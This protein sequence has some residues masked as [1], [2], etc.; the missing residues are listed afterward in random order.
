VIVAGDLGLWSAT[1]RWSVS[2]V[3]VLT[4]RS[5]M[6]ERDVVYVLKN[7]AAVWV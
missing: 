7:L 4:V 5:D 6:A 3:V 2:W 1:G